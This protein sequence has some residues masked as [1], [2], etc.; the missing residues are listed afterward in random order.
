MWRIRPSD[1]KGMEVQIEIEAVAEPIRDLRSTEEQI[2]IKSQRMENG[3]NRRSEVG[4]KESGV[5]S[6]DLV[7]GPSKEID[8][9]SSIFLKERMEGGSSEQPKKKKMRV[10]R[11]DVITKLKDDGDFDSLRL[12]PAPT[13]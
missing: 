3:K 4:V 9:R 7:E 11:D 2:R 8:R 10:S 1:E 12:K 13:F 5:L 6:S